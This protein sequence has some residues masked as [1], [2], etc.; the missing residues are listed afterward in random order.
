MKIVQSDFG[1]YKLIT[2]SETKNVI[3][4]LAELKLIVEDTLA[5]GGRHIA[6]KFTDASYL[7]SGAISVLVTC[8]RLLHD[9]GGNICIVEPHQRVNDLLIQMNI[10]SFINIC[11][12]EDE[13]L[14]LLN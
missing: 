9:K 13:L 11:G 6:V 12:S 5:R 4:E 14:T 1:M 2:V 10:D 8:Y 7:Y 3:P